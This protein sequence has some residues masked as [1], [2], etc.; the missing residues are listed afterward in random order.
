MFNNRFNSTKKD[1]LV[2]AVQIAM[3][4]GE[5]RRQAEALVN[6]EFGVFNRRAVVREQLAAY[7]AAIEEAYKCMKEAPDTGESDAR[8]TVTSSKEAKEKVFAKH[9]ERMKKLDDKPKA[10]YS[11]M[12]EKMVGK[13]KDLETTRKIVGEAK[14]LADKDYD[15]DGKV[16]SP[17]DEV[18]G[19][20]FRAAKMAGKMEEEQIDE[21]SKKTLGSYIKKAASKKPYTSIH[22]AAY[23]AA[24]GDPKARKTI[25]KREKGIER[26][27]DRLTKEETQIDEISKKLA[28]K[29]MK[30]SD[31]RGE[32][33]YDRDMTDDR[34]SDPKTHWDRA[35]RLR[36]HMKRKFGNKTIK[37][38]GTDNLS[39]KSY[40][41][42]G[43]ERRRADKLKKGPR[44]GMISAKHRDKLKDNIKYSLGKHK[45]PN[46]PEEVDYS[47]PD[48]AA[49]TRDN[50]P[51]TPAQTNAAT[52]GPSAADKAALTNKIKTMKEAVYSAKAARAGKDIGKPGK[53]FKKIAAKAGEKYGS[54]ERGKKVAGAILKRIR[55]K[56]MKEENLEELSAFG[57][58]FAAA[59]GQ[60]FTFG[61]KQYSGAMKGQTGS[62]SSSSGP[63]SNAGLRGATGF[64]SRNI[65]TSKAEPNPRLGSSSSS[66]PQDN[67]GLRGSSMPQTPKAPTPADRWNASRS[68]TST[69]APA[70]TGGPARDVGMTGKAGGEKG[71]TS[72]S[73]VSLDRPGN[74][75]AS[76]PSSPPEQSRAAPG[77]F[78]ARSAAGEMKADAASAGVKKLMSMN[79][80]VQVGANRYRIV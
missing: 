23:D 2:E 6:E 51:S 80:S 79:E 67:P 36:G 39:P 12:R 1:S 70:P 47:A 52:S 22:G 53:E 3:Q 42:G 40:E 68:S 49:V 69:S 54:E 30:K 5:I 74:V 62:S 24:S 13:G 11:K 8:K 41:Q 38:G 59:K 72:G 64:P 58:A 9:K 43:G 66:G 29:A 14:K 19:S 78:A 48:R 37:T 65:S 28:L 44:A 16:E 31:E 35:K 27:T 18:W 63:Q 15:K 26:A 60:N 73:T 33:E 71:V 61:G 25:Q 7:D 56:H 10:D 20:R 50:K 77:T 4:D 57:K 34:L 55:A 21:V 76:T 17:K 45:K 75:G 32:E 46:L